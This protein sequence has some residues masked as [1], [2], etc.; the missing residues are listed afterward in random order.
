MNINGFKRCRIISGRSC[1]CTRRPSPGKKRRDDDGFSVDHGV[2]HPA[3]A[4]HGFF[5]EKD[6]FPLRLPTRPGTRVSSPGPVSV[7]SGGLVDFASICLD[8][9]SESG[10]FSQDIQ[11]FLIG[12]NPISCR[13]CGLVKNA[14]RYE[15]LHG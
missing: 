1:F 9:L 14:K 6:V 15:L 13:I 7:S 4:A 3:A 2:N 12:K 8:L 5:E 10:V 11:V